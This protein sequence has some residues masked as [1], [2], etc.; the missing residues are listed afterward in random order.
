MIST[1]RTDK[2]ASLSQG[3]SARK[4]LDL[5][6]G[7]FGPPLRTSALILPSFFFHWAH[8]QLVV[9][10]ALTTGPDREQRASSGR[11]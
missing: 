11:G 5:R 7:Y 2:E 6:D 1:D 4:G 10:N 9:S 8:A 3:R